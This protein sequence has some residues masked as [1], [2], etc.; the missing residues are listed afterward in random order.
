MDI[1]INYLFMK[2]VYNATSI[3]EKVQ[4]KYKNMFKYKI[5]LKNKLIYNY[6]MIIILFKM[7]INI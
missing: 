4:I 5:K 1:Q 3:M 7:K 2:S 6:Q